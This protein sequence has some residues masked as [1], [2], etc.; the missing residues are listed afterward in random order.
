MSLSESVLCFPS[1]CLDGLDGG[2]WHGFNSRVAVLTALFDNSTTSF[3]FIRR[4][5]CEQD[6]SYK[7]VIPYSIIQYGRKEYDNDILIFSYT[8]GQSGGEDRLKKLKSIGIGGHVDQSVERY[9]NSIINKYKRFENHSHLIELGY[10]RWEAQREIEE[11][12]SYKSRNPILHL[13]GSINDD[14]NDVGRVHFGV[15]YQLFVTTPY[16]AAKEAAIGDPEMLRL[17]DLERRIEEY[18]PWSQMVIRHLVENGK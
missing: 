11:E 14:S 3:Q 15:V 9:K 17:G 10:T 2:R 5:L 7:Q 18:E 12:I 13:L 6:T 16:V 8:R 1:S 4:D